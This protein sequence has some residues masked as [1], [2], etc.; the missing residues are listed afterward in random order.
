MLARGSRLEPARG[1]PSAALPGWSVGVR[2][3]L[4]P[5]RRVA[6]IRLRDRALGTSGSTMQFF[7]HRG[8]R[9]AHILDPKTGRPADGVLSATVLAPSAALADALSTALFVMGPEQAL[10]FC[11]TR[12]EIAALLICPGG[13]RGRYE[14][15]TTGFQ[16]GELSL[17]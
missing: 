4:D 11:R 8:R 1:K 5:R 14:I 9:Y 15:H 10:A 17:L 16:P 3:P 13:S 6:E 7:R 2:N 12:P